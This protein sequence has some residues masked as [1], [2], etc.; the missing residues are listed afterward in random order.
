MTIII[1]SLVTHHS[2]GSTRPWRGPV[3]ASCNENVWN[4]AMRLGFNIA[5]LS[6]DRRSDCLFPHMSEGVQTRF[7]G[8]WRGT[9]A[10]LLADLTGALMDRCSRGDV[11]MCWQGYLFIG[12]HGAKAGRGWPLLRRPSSI[13]HHRGITLL[14]YEFLEV[15]LRLQ[16]CRR[17]FG[18]RCELCCPA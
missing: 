18:L 6:A 14:C 2:Q 13:P 10:G 3:K 7:G 17:I 1:I 15:L 9:P 16:K 4:V 11:T 5:P 12:P 8:E